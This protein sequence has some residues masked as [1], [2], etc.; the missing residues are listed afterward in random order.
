LLLQEIEEKKK[1]TEIEANY[2]IKSQNN[3]DESSSKVFSGEM[4][5]GKNEEGMNKVS[6]M[7]KE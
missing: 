5:D 3:D 7:V 1:N 2:N 4:K 6:F